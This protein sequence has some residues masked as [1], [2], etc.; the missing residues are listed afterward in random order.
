VA[1]S[2]PKALYCDKKN[3]FVL[4]REPTDAEILKGIT[5]PK[6]H[7][8]KACDK[9]GIEVIPAKSATQLPRPQAKGR[10]ERNHKTD[11]DRL[12]KELRLA[13]ISTMEAANTFLERTYLPKMNDKFSV[14]PAGKEE[15]HVPLGNT[16]LDDIF[17]FEEERVVSND[18]VVRHNCR[19]YQIEKGRNSLPHPKDK[20]LVRERLDG[21]ML[22]VWHGKP[23]SIREIKT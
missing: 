21:V 15:A 4:T 11:Q 10:V 5:K 3:A 7:F 20:V 1:T 14:P 6:S 23:L 12:V 16:R 19:F 18:Y 17:C 2:L 9:L 13:G 8:G 22:I